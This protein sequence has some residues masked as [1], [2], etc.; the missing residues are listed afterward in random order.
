MG[1]TIG[2]LQA[3]ESL[4]WARYFMYTQLYFHPVRRIYD[5]HLT[6]FLR[7]ALHEGKYSTDLE[8]HLRTTDNEIL[9]MVA[10]AASDLGKPGHDP[11]SRIV[12]RSH[13]RL[14]YEST[15]AD[16]QRNLKAP[17]LISKA[18]AQEF[19][20]TQIRYNPY[21]SDTDS[22]DFPVYQRD[23]S[24][25]SSVQLSNT[26]AQPPRFAVHYVFVAPEVKEKA[27]T[28]LEQNK[29]LILSSAEGV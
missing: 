13:F 1:I 10:E 22:E 8:Q 5:I 18:A 21:S 19:G 17:Q 29:D 28:W 3:A 24:V 12:S 9:A 27:K 25:A 26:F 20:D 23:G 2:G 4:L 11:A 7:E 14:L 16:L 15:P 6:E